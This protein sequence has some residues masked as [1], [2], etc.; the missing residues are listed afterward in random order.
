MIS[1]LIPSWFMILL[2]LT[3]V[4][5][6]CDDVNTI[7]CQGLNNTIDVCSDDCFSQMCQRFCGKCPLKCY[8]CL[9]V[10][11]ATCTSTEECPNNHSS[12]IQEK[13]LSANYSLEY[14][15]GCV[16][17]QVCNQLYGEGCQ[18][19]GVCNDHRGSCCKTD[20]CNG[21]ASTSKAK[22]EVS[23]RPVTRETMSNSAVCH[24]ID[25]KACTSFKSSVAE[26][27]TRSCFQ[28]SC[29]RTC[30]LC[31]ECAYC[32]RIDRPVNCNSTKICSPGEKCYT[33]K[34]VSTEGV[35]KYRLG[36]LH[37]KGCET[38]NNT[39][40]HAIGR[41]DGFD[42]PVEGD[43][44]AGELCN[45]IKPIPIHFGTSCS[46]R[47]YRRALTWRDCVPST[48]AHPY[49]TFTSIS[50]SP[51][52]VLIPGN[53]TIGVC[54]T[55]HHHFSKNVRMVVHMDKHLLGV[56]TNI[57]CRNNFGSC[58]YDNPCEVLS[59]FATS[60]TCPP[61]L[62]AHGIPCTCPFNPSDINLPP[63]VF[64]V[65]TIN[66]SWSWFVTGR[67]RVQAELF[68]RF[69]LQKGLFVS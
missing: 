16:T 31:V 6:S 68:C 21:I 2:S 18:S 23:T 65:K 39:V 46:R 50:V 51:S 4:V 52:P 17:L 1:N 20:L 57:P 45:Q 66:A 43:C 27:C 13:T 54:G 14:R 62:E 49:V 12:C 15:L 30:G 41:S 69:I 42:I 58:N 24:D 26:A 9:S 36:C 8:H 35:H 11:P 67:F 63:S 55:I 29:P 19:P 33:M 34:M 40:Q 60:G 28:Q 5:Y 56:W 48:T 64:E 22:L 32:P 47:R 61:Q 7:A 25:L 37:E 38:M 3:S 10:N 44:C 53:I 59:A